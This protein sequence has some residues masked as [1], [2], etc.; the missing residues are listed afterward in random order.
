MISLSLSDFILH[1]LTMFF[2]VSFHQDD[3]LKAD[4]TL[5]Y[6]DEEE[7]SRYT[8][9]LVSLSQMLIFAET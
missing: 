7:H 5:S 8:I 3:C 6:P 1:H 9:H 2:P 4:S